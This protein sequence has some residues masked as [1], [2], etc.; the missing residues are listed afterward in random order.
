MKILFIFTGGTIASQKLGNT[1]S[2]NDNS[3]SL[4][5]E[6]YNKKVLFIKS[7]F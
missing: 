4:L 7:N 3:K 5:L 2:L 1:I 6:L